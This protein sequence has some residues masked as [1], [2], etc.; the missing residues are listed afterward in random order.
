MYMYIVNMYIIKNIL[1]YE[2]IK[3][4]AKRTGKIVD[5]DLAM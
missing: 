4:L 1:S 5:K 3:Q 2:F